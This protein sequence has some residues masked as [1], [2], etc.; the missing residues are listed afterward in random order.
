MLLLNVLCKEAEQQLPRTLGAAFGLVTVHILP[1]QRVG[2]FKSNYLSLI[3]GHVTAN[4]I[5]IDTVSSTPTGDKLYSKQLTVNAI[6]NINILINKSIILTCFMASL[7]C[8]LI[9]C[10]MPISGS[11][12][13]MGLRQKSIQCV[14]RLR[15]RM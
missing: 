13:R 12:L 8:L 1:K 14:C 9:E 5:D 7:Y 3:N 4:I 11:E 15:Q 2:R 6:A 10:R